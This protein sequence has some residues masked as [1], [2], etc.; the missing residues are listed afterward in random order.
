MPRLAI[1][2]GSI[3]YTLLYPFLLVCLFCSLSLSTSKTN[4]LL[5]FVFQIP[6]WISLIYFIVFVFSVIAFLKLAKALVWFPSLFI[7]IIRHSTHVIYSIYLT[8][9][10]DVVYLILIGLI[11]L[12]MSLCR[13]SCLC[14]C[15]ANDGIK[16]V[17]YY[18]LF[19]Y[20]LNF[21]GIY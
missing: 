8:G 16:R 17:H 21:E 6:S 5:F 9:F 15:L 11:E 19:I 10:W 18:T 3:H 12:P 2:Q 7:C 1:L 20:F 13:A 14:L 4:Y